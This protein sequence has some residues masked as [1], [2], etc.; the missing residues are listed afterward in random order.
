MMQRSLPALALLVQILLWAPRLDL[1]PLWDDE[2]YTLQTAGRSLAGIV[3]A[4]QVDVH[5][6]LYYVLV[7]E[8]L[9]LPLPGEP[10][11]RA[12]ALSVLLALAATV[13]FDRLWLRRLDFHHRVLFLGLWVSSPC[14][15]LYARMARSYSLQI[16]LAVAAIRLARDWLHDARNRRLEAGYTLAATALLYSHYLPGLAVV[17]AVTALGVWRR[18]WIRLRAV[19]WIALAYLPWMATLYQTAGMVAAAKPYWLGANWMV[20]N[21]LKLGYVFVAFQFGETAPPWALG[22]GLLL[23]PALGAALWRAWRFHPHPPTLFV[24]LAAGGYFI[25]ASWVSFAFVGARLLFLLPFYYLFLTQGL[26]I[27]R[28]RGVLTYAGL[29][30]IAGGG[31]HSYYQQRHFLNKGYLV[32][33]DQIARR[34]HQGTRGGTAFVLLDR[35]CASAGYALHGP[36]I[37]YVA[38]VDSE[39]ARRQALE[40]IARRRPERVWYIHYPRHGAVHPELS[41]HLEAGYDLQRHGFIPYSALDRAAMRVIGLTPQP[42]YVIEVLEFRRSVDKTRDD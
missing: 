39:A 26:D 1:L 27:R 36:Q 31:L 38:L 28:A 7:R 18:E 40:R 23:L 29:L 24:W 9:K 8:W 11:E 25:A 14:L 33:F 34:V 32:D 37:P 13:L 12:R 21:A 3:R 4:V 19:G 42:E 5:P 10:L 16:L 41:R 22:L 30:V 35:F 6:P 17:G 20:E 2:R 15:A